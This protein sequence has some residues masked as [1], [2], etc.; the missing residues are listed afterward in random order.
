MS[1][2]I[3]TNL[4]NLELKIHFL[5]F[6]YNDFGGNYTQEEGRKFI[7][8]FILVLIFVDDSVNFKNLKTNIKRLVCKSCCCEL[9]TPSMFSQSKEY[10]QIIHHDFSFN[11][12]D[13][14]LK[15]YET[16]QTKYKNFE[17]QR[18]LVRKNS[19]QKLAK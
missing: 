17:N 18:I 10:A 1:Y 8:N 14:I 2:C 6:A 19:L 9:T 11:C 5:L 4:T 15:K 12:I 3:R 16:V 7:S 13:C